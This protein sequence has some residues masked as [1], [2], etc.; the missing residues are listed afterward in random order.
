MI[1]KEQ[2]L[3]IASLSRIHL[4][5]AEAESLA[6]DLECILKYIDQ[7]NEVDVSGVKP[8]SHALPLQ[9]VFR[10]DVVK[11]SFTQEQALQFAVD[12]YKGCYKVPK[13]IE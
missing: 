11:P 12:K 13:V 1:T 5:E 2:A 4:K 7:L 6:S 3:K 8:T 10:E 9:N